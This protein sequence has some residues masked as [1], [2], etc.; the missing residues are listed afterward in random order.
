MAQVIE[1]AHED[2]DVE[3]FAELPDVV[4]GQVAELDVGKSGDLGGEASL[5]EIDLVAVDA[6][7]AAGA[8]LDS[9]KKFAPRS[10]LRPVAPFGRKS[11]ILHGAAT[12][13]CA[14]I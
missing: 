7:D 10:V 3:C 2:D 12:G 14:A 8:A 1:H 4:D 5:V 9:S 13:D 6:D 11:T